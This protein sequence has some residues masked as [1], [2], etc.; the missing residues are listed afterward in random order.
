VNPY[1]ELGG[2]DGV[3]E[4]VVGFYDAMDRLP[5][6]RGIRAMHAD[7]LAPMREAL[8][9][10]LS[11]WLGG[12]QIYFDR[13]DPKCI[14]S[15]HAPYAIGP[16]ERDAWVQCM[17]EAVAASGIEPRIQALLRGAFRR[18]ADALRT[19]VE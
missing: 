4:L 9:A 5:E 3:R 18:V 15:A 17:D 6:A 12:P 11:G 14:R 16:A 2:E 19:D 10:Y 7:D 1:D 8:F 13:P